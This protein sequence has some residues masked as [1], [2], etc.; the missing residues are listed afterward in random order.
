VLVLKKL[1]HE[2]DGEFLEVIK[3]L[4]KDQQMQVSFQ[5]SD[6]LAIN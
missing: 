2:L 5:S 3:W 6:S 1:G 4:S